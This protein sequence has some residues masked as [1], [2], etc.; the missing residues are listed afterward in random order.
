MAAAAGLGH[1]LRFG[2]SSDKTGMGGLFVGRRIMTLVAG[3]AGKLMIFIEFQVVA[4][5]ALAERKVDR[6]RRP[7]RRAAPGQQ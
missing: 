5:G 3:Y 6:R 4:G 1:P 7:F 2:R